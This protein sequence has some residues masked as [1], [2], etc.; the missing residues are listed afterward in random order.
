M[1]LGKTLTSEEI[2]KIKVLKETSDMSNRQ[3]AKVIGRDEKV[4]RNYLIDP[5]NYGKNRKGSTSC[6]SSRQK[7]LLFRCASNSLLSAREMRDEIGLAVGVRRTQQLLQSNKNLEYRKLLTKPMLSKSNIEVRKQFAIDHMSWTSEWKKIIFSDEKKFNLDGPD[8]WTY[9][10]HDLR[11]EKKIFAQRQSGGGSVMVWGAIG[12]LK[13]LNLVFVENTMN[14]E[15]YQN[16]VG[17]HFP[18]YGF[19]LAG[20]G[21]IFQQD[22]API[23]RA[24]STL[25]YFR[26]RNIGLLE[27]WP[28]KSPDLNIIE[29]LWSILARR[30]YRHGRHYNS[31]QELKDSIVREWND[32]N[33]ATVQNLYHSMQRRMI[34]LYDAKGNSTKY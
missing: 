29:N 9:Y 21:W 14:A 12:Y 7:Q 23:H 25:S 5:D 4:I 30:V 31:K 26:D 27:P 10:W 22:N 34:A 13:K 8:G 6:V 3:I 15:H 2:S 1:G 11:T 20:L 24:R 19:E 17:P 16:M 32:I 28:S 18:A 33:Q